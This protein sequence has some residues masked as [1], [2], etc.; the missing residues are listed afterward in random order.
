MAEV[1]ERWRR[2]VVKIKL[3]H[4]THH[5]SPPIANGERSIQLLTF[6]VGMQLVTQQATLR[7]KRQSTAAKVEPSQHVQRVTRDVGLMRGWG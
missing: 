3:L 5:I 7:L 6:E 1:R 4:D 2:C